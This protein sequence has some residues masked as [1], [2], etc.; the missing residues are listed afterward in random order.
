M[1]CPMFGRVLLLAVPWGCDVLFSWLYWVEGI[2]QLSW[3]VL[4]M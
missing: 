1:Y 3:L 4:F 2:C